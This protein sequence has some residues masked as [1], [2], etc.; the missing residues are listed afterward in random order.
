[1]GVLEEI[2]T[3]RKKELEFERVREVLIGVT[4]RVLN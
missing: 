1:M 4:T 2:G 3:E